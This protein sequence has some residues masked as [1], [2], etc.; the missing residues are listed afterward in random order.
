MEGPASPAGAHT[1]PG[2][3]GD[4]TSSARY[5][6]SLAL[7]GRPVLVV[8]GG[9][10][11]QRKVDA[12]VLAGADVTVVATEATQALCR[13]G[14]AHRLAL[15]QR[16]FQSTDLAGQ[17]LAFAAT[18]DAELNAQIAR[19]GRL[20]G[21]LVNDASDSECGDFTLPAVHRAGAVCVA[22]DTSAASPSFAKRV[23]DD[24]AAIVDERY[25]RA[26]ESLAR[27]RAYALKALTRSE[28]AA[29]M[30]R[31]AEA[32]LDELATMPPAST[33]DAVDRVAGD[34]RARNVANSA[35][36]P[37]ICA[38]RGSALAVWQAR[39]VMTLLAEHG[40]AS[41][42]L[43][44]TTTGDRATDR[45]LNALGTDSVFVRELETALR[46][47]RADYAVHSCKDLP[48]TL[49]HDMH[50]AAVS[51]REDPR[52]ALCSERFSSM[53]A[54]PAGA[55]VGT[56][57]PRRLAQLRA[58]RPDLEFEPIRGNIDTR[59]RKLREGRY[60][61]IVLAMA[62][63]TRLGLR[64]THTIPLDPS[65][66]VPAAG[67]GALAIECR[68]ED[69]AT[70][71]LTHAAVSDHAA[72][73]SVAAERAF[74]RAL[75][76]GCQAPVGAFATL[77]DSRLT[78]TGIVAALDGTRAVRG[79]HTRTIANVAEAAEVGTALATALQRCCRKSR[80]NAC[81]K[82]RFFCYRARRTATAA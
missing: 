11:A 38:T 45:P 61:A 41:T 6:I 59:L 47:R 50:L 68:A 42:I 56:S 26:A 82:G 80:T 12:L 57:S 21:V 49:A 23:R 69:D 46:E 60:D 32:D 16:P 18:D 29:V 52:D 13:L 25:A 37:L 63:L 39:H 53:A 77:D 17:V 81:S 70:I 22:I 67:Q 58:L 14:E 5:P 78:L 20:R 79:K 24:V 35:A 2:D 44:V 31:L 43:T 54:L 33:E 40:T 10:V 48:S 1:P 76:A 65:E 62:G 4:R 73:L 74:L 19:E 64:A 8:G 27:M 30:G 51:V 9:S 75:R 71:E 15:R 7:S 55:V 3:P 66:V 72:E 28:R 34:L 36:H